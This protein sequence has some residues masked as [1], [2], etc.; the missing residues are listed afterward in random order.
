[1]DNLSIRRPEQLSLALGPYSHR[2]PIEQLRD[3]LERWVVCLAY[4]PAPYEQ[5]LVEFQHSRA[6]RLA[7]AEGLIVV[8][9]TPVELRTLALGSDS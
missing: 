3:D 2:C 5:A 4:R 6:V 1:V 8:A 7:L 9:Y